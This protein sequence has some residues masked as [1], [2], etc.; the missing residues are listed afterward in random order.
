VGEYDQNARRL[1]DLQ[2]Q[3]REVEGG[4]QEALHE[5]KELLHQ[6]EEAIVGGGGER[7]YAAEGD[8]CAAGDGR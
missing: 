3:L 7:I 8:R 1:A 4:A 2:A 5:R 6:R